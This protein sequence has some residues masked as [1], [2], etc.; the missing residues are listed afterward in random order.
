[1]RD[2]P[3]HLRYD[4]VRGLVQTAITTGPDAA[5]YYDDRSAGY[6]QTSN[7][8]PLS[9]GHRPRWATSPTPQGT[10]TRHSGR[11]ARPGPARTATYN[12]MRGGYALFSV[13]SGNY[14]F[15]STLP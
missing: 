11:S 14:V 6:R 3:D 1:M 4:V 5:V 7:L 15:Q 12:G 2:F 8:L 9:V 13:G 10:S